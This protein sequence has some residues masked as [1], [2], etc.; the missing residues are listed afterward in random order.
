LILLLKFKRRR[1]LVLLAAF[2]ISYSTAYY[3]R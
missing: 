2:F 1:V 3:E